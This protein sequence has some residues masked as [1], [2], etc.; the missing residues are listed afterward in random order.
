[1]ARRGAPNHEAEVIDAR[2]RRRWLSWTTRTIRDAQGHVAYAVS[3]GI[4]VTDRKRLEIELAGARTE[5]A[6]YGGRS[7]DVLAIAAHDLRSPLTVIEWQAD[8][9]REWAEES[10]ESNVVT[11]MRRVLSA[12]HQMSALISDVL[13]VSILGAGIQGIDAGEHDLASILDEV[14]QVFGPWATAHGVRVSRAST[15]TVSLWCDRRKISRVFFNLLGNAAKFTPRGGDIVI[16]IFL[17]DGEVICS[18]KDTGPGIPHDYADR[19]FE[20]HFTRGGRGGTGLG[21]FIARALISA[22]GGRIWVEDGQTCGAKV[23]FALPL[24]SSP[25]P[26]S[27]RP[28]PRPTSGVHDRPS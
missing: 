26:R 15:P 4:D 12:A 23:C 17:G 18:V 19:I 6:V 27:E 10:H 14:L 11:A 3:T 5:H 25:A 28:V 7:E 2:G 1:L 16:D 8:A 21:L 9:L 22:H 20:R 24:R 13:D